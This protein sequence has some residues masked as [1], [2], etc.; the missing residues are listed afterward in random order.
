LGGPRLIFIKSVFDVP[1]LILQGGDDQTLPIGA[2]HPASAK[3]VQNATLKVYTGAPH[4]LTETNQD[5]V[6][7]GLLAFLK[8][9]APL[10]ENHH[11]CG[12]E[13]PPRP[14]NFMNSL[15]PRPIKSSF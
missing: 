10:E 2:A 6:N 9:Q 7:A 5:Q 4:G 14:E 13:P 1:A 11:V 3:C 12:T 8:A 15:V